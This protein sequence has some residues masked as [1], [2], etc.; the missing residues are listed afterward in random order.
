MSSAPHEPEVMRRGRGL[1]VVDAAAIIVGVVVGAGIFRMP[2]LVAG[3]AG[4]ETNT[5]L[6]WL[7]GGGISL[8][9]AFCYAELATA[10]PN[11][12]G[13]YHFL[14]RSFG[15]S[16]S[17]LFAWARMTI[18]QPGSIALQAY[19]IGDYMSQVVPLGEASP[20]LY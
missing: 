7:L 12:G 15:K 1:S 16:V 3:N 20:S 17:F 18:I 19:I 8:I 9:G 5:M 4:N 11:V 13:D 6:L 2:G 10:F 14:S